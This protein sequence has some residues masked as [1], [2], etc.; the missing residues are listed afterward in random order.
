M[1]TS[2]AS[3]AGPGR[4][5]PLIVDAMNVLASRPDGWWRDREAAY[6]RLI[7][8]LRPV[9]AART[10]VV[11]VVVEGRAGERLAAGPDGD[12]EVV[13]ATR[14]GGDAAD[15]TI[16]EL[17]SD[18]AVSQ[19]TVVTADRE[20]RRRA[21]NAGALVVGPQTLRRSFDD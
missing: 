1:E 18:P 17:L 10:G 5:G 21:I 15:D 9:A 4:D 3:A 20:L 12:V 6:R 13:H 14:R 19:A 8:Q 2:A 16:V 11:V 7:E